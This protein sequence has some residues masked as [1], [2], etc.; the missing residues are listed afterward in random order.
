MSF[1]I[2]RSHHHL[3]DTLELVKGEVLLGDKDD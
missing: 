2:G 1:Q 3:Q